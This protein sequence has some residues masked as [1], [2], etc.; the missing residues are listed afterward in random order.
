M[1]SLNDDLLALKLAILRDD[2]Q[3]RS[4]AQ[5]QT[6]TQTTP[7]RHNW[8]HLPP[9]ET[10]HS[11]QLSSASS[12]EAATALETRISTLLDRFEALTTR[13]QKRK[14]K[15]A[16]EPTVTESDMLRALAQQSAQLQG[17]FF[18]EI[19]GDQVV[20]R[21]PRIHHEE[22]QIEPKIVPAPSIPS[23]VPQQT[24]NV[25][26]VIPRTPRTSVISVR[27]ASD[28]V[29][30]NRKFR[31]I[32]SSVLFTVVMLKKSLAF[33]QNPENIDSLLKS[34]QEEFISLIKIQRPLF[35]AINLLW[36]VTKKPMSLVYKSSFTNPHGNG[37]RAHR[38]IVQI[39]DYTISAIEKINLRLLIKSYKPTCK[40][41]RTFD[42]L[43]S[44]NI[45]Y[46][47]S[48]IW[49]SES[50]HLSNPD[51][52]PSTKQPSQPFAKNYP[53]NKADP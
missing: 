22:P 15:V 17:L 31:I 47:P 13:L 50:T 5:S 3:R 37:R 12:S 24:R 45:S 21:P 26:V 20:P 1:S 42:H 44:T 53:S 40:S 38:K 34:S 2:S 4:L 30:D 14:P 51:T 49:K 35:H 32:A 23:I 43:I 41:L 10:H 36:T 8:Q 39:I 6:Q 11:I 16:P 48:Y 9:A 46:P 29:P 7:L 25:S 52:L 18:A 33:R 27:P 19:L 28:R